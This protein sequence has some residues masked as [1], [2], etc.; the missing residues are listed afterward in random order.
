MTRFRPLRYVAVETA[1]SI[2]ANMIIATVPALLF[3][4]SGGMH[5]GAGL[6]GPQLVMCA[7]MSA[8]VPSF[9]TRR[10]CA[11]GRLGV[12]GEPPDMV[13]VAGTAAALA[14]LFA[15][16]VLACSHLVPPRLIAGDRGAATALLLTGAQAM[17]A[18]LIVTPAALV[19]L[20]GSNWQCRAGSARSG[21]TD[22][23][24]AA[25]SASG[26]SASG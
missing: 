4:E 23:R 19:L 20:F 15:S 9:L 10:R 22:R 13:R 25:R 24:D 3:W 5:A 12:Y 7:F 26:G 18:G 16:L 1:I 8:F 2:V 17:L 11:N 6:L 14:V 21:G